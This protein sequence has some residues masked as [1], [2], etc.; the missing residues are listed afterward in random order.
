MTYACLWRGLSHETM[1]AHTGTAQHETNRRI[2]TYCCCCC[3]CCCRVVNNAAESTSPVFI[4]HPNGFA[5]P[6]HVT[7]IRSDLNRGFAKRA[8]YH[9]TESTAYAQ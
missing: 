6:G 1:H 3:C 2:L 5:F 9:E 4:I 7:E 8:C